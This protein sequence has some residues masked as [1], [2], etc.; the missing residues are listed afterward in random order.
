M[1][2]WNPWHG[3]RKL[4]E[5]CRHCYIYRMDARYHKDASIIYQTRDFD[6]PLK[7]KRD[8][9]YQLKPDS[10]VYTCFT[11]DFLLEEADAWRPACWEM[12]RKR[13]DLMFLFLTKRI[14]RFL[15]CV[16]DDWGSGYPNVIV[17][18][19]V[20]NADCAKQRLPLFQTLP[21]LHKTIVCQP[22]LGAIDLSPYLRDSIDQVV[23]GGEM[24]LEA[25]VCDYDWVLQI[26]EQC[27]KANVSFIFRQTGANF[28]KDGKLYRIPRKYQFSQAKKAGLNTWDTPVKSRKK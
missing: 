16:P 13:S 20:E 15:D 10:L 23:V 1:S 19:T 12:M 21:I 22:L 4:S 24:G 25:R 17:G 6:L 5:G 8:Q 28:R 2:D 7:R 26:H 18:C 3:C 27:K 9:E 14:D 11:S